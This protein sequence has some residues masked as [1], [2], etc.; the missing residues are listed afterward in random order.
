MK[1][2][3]QQIAECMATYPVSPES[4][5]RQTAYRLTL[6]DDWE[7]QAGDRVLEIGCGQGDTTAVLAHRVGPNGRVLAVDKG[8][9]H[10]GAPI[11]IGASMTHL[12]AGPLGSAL[13]FRLA[14]DITQLAVPSEPVY[15]VAVLAHC[16]WYLSNPEELMSLLQT[17]QHWAHRLCITE[18]DLQAE[19]TPFNPHRIAVRIQ[20]RIERS[21]QNSTANIRWAATKDQVES[22]LIATGWQVI[23]R[24]VSQSS[25]LEDGVWE[26][27]NSLRYTIKDLD[28]LSLSEVERAQLLQDLETLR[29]VDQRQI[30]ASL[31]SFTV[32]AQ[33]TTST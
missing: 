27:Q 9:P 23:Q 4:Q 11:T 21:Q 5:V 26:V 29:D 30:V 28:Q 33:P 6:A 20:D 14:T 3:A 7:I 22:L 31:P 2:V 10:Y 16:L 8:D 24:K 25:G 32:I 18:W 17:L 12:S 19:G 15:D 13:E 1:R